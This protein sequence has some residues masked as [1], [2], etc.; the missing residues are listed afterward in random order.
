M[1]TI[2]YTGQFFRHLIDSDVQSCPSMWEF[3]RFPAFYSS[4]GHN[5]VDILHKDLIPQ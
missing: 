5:I 4:V 1:I 3:G 2:P